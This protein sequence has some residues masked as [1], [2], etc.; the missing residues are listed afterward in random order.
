ME[1]IIRADLARPE[2]A[3]AVLALLDAY[4]RDPMGG[5]APLSD[6]VRQNLIAELRTRPAIR[7]LLAF[8][9]DAPA[10]LA[11]CIEGFSSFACKPLLN[12]HDLVVLPPYRG[13]GLS[14][15]LLTKVEEIAR[16]L[17]CCKLT[18]EVLSGNTVAQ[19]AYRACGF[20]GYELR[21]ET[22]KALF[23]EKPLP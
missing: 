4:A 2:H 20:T 5:G 21:P 10:G 18:L 22:G 7:L 13:R 9:D 14:K 12:I 16:E 15:R 11:L 6:F 19:A 1:T 23:W 3:E 17:G 8:V